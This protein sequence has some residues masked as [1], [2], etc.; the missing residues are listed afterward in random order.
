MPKPD[1]PREMLPERLR[2]LPMIRQF[3]DER[4]AILDGAPSV[5]EG[6]PAYARA[7]IVH[8]LEEH[9]R[10]SGAP[11]A[12]ARCGDDLRRA[13]RSPYEAA[14]STYCSRK[15]AHEARSARLIARRGFQQPQDH[16]RVSSRAALLPSLQRPQG[17]A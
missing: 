9:H 11:L 3:Y 15:C 13:Y 1:F 8:A 17:D 7:L 5:H 14:R 6:A 2:F 4:A 16:L 10:R 12:C